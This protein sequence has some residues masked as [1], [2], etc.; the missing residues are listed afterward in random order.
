MPYSTTGVKP[1]ISSVNGGVVM[2]G[3]PVINMTY[4]ADKFVDGLKVGLVAQFNSDNKVANY[5]SGASQTEAGVVAY[6]PSAT[7]DGGG[8]YNSSN[9]DISAEVIEFGVVSVIVKTG[10][11]PT[12]FGQVYVSTSSDSLGQVQTSATNGN[13]YDNAVFFAKISDSVWHIKIT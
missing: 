10:Q 8:T 5:G 1:E 4:P 11:T 9:L 12:K 13:I 7:I 3:T 6:N 2:S